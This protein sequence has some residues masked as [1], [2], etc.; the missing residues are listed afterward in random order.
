LT[1]TGFQHDIFHAQVWE[2]VL[3]Q[4]SQD[5]RVCLFRPQSWN[6]QLR[7]DFSFLIIPEMSTKSTPKS[8][9]VNTLTQ[10]IISKNNLELT[11]CAKRT[12][13]IW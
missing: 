5:G 1:T 12:G 3:Q 11:V 13:F 6:S 7:K 2:A 8:Q 10:N 9:F 4:K